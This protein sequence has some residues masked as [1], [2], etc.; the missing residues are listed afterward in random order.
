VR[1]SLGKVAELA[2]SARLFEPILTCENISKQLLVGVI[3]RY[4]NRPDL[5]EQLRKVAAILLDDGQ[6]VGTGAMDHR[7]ESVVRSRRLRDRFPCGDLQA[8]VDLYRSGVTARRV[9]EEF[10]VSLRSVKRL[11]REHGIRR[12]GRR[13]S[14]QSGP[15]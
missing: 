3:R 9:A 11:L 14:R 4:S 13:R 1:R 10:E 15:S 6:G 7:T 5:L 12:E 2:P 8:M